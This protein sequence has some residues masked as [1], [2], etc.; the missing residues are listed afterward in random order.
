MQALIQAPLLPLIKI[1]NLGMLSYEGA[2]QAMRRFTDER[3]ESTLDEL[4]ILE[5]PPVFTLGQAGLKK[6][7]KNLK[8]IPLILSDRGGQITYHGPG[9]KI[10]Y[11][12]L[13]LK[14]RQLKIGELTHIIQTTV[15][16]T[17]QQYQLKAH[18]IEKAPGVYI[19]QAK[20]CSLGLRLR[21]NCTYHGLSLNLNMNL[22][23][24]TSINP[25]GYPDLKVTQLINFMDE[26][27]ANQV[28]NELIKHLCKA[29]GYKQTD[30]QLTMV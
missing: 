22:E 14:R 28:F 27:S 21:R 11:F 9:Q 25:C 5:H 1:R 2:W 6:H 8:N 12:L 7:I 16:Q 10:I 13:D 23:P 15:M 24:F 17:L 4:W 19:N 3:D 30:S 18:L 26:A 20:I 29:L